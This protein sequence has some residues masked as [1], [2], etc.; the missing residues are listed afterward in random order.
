MKTYTLL[1]AD[2]V[3]YTSTEPGLLGGHS[4]TQRLRA[5][6]L[7]GR[8]E[9]PA[10]RVH[11]RAT[12]SSSPTRRPR[13]PPAT[14]RAGRACVRST[15]RGRR[16]GAIAAPDHHVA[17][18]ARDRRPPPPR[19]RARRRRAPPSSSARRSAPA[20]RSRRA[21]R[22]PRRHDRRPP[23]R[24]RPRPRPR[25]STR[26]SGSASSSRS[27]SSSCCAS[28][29]RRAR[30]RAR[31]PAQ[32]LGLRRD[33]VP[34]QHHRRRIS[35]ARSRAAAQARARPPARRRS[36]AP[37]RRAA[38]SATSPWAPPAP[39][40]PAQLPGARRQGGGAGAARGGHQRH[41]RA[42]RRRPLGA[43]RGDG[44]PRVLAAIPRA[45]ATR[46][47]PRSTAGCAGGVAADRQALPRAW[48]HDRQHRPAAPRRSAPARRPRADLAPF[49]AAIAGPRAA[50]HELAR[51]SIRGSTRD[52]IA[53]QS[54][55]ILRTC[56]ATSCSYEGVVITDSIE[57][58]AVRATG[59]DRAGRGALDPRRQRHRADHR[60]GLV[61]PGLSGA[62][63]R[64]ACV[65]GR[66]ARASRRPRR[67]W[68]RSS[69][70][71]RR[72]S[73]RA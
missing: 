4:R 41:A 31:G 51:A 2:G 39:P 59:L 65:D 70:R 10:A 48:R 49:K 34:R 40:R 19:G 64:G 23:R 47:R 35:C 58:A 63:R 53:S 7:P 16:G 9:P 44:R 43:R 6:R 13:S 36:S 18:A 32:G 37:T 1:G 21:A 42:R 5:A 56:C 14:G 17:R 61:D 45:A 66:S 29:A 33:P 3:P 27:A 55:A 28:R 30:L 62:A 26:S 73:V 11:A 52:R 60:P 20:T 12:A 38:R 8:A 46:P 25:A 71:S 22:R 68:S 72:T 57:A 54:P 50:D 69:T 15:G 67:A 24:P